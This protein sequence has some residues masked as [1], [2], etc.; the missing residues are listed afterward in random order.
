[1]DCK[2][3]LG[4]GKSALIN[5]ICGDD[6]AMESL[7]SHCEETTEVTKYEKRVGNFTVYISDTL[8]LDNVDPSLKDWSCEVDLKM[9]GRMDEVMLLSNSV[10]PQ[11]PKSINLLFHPFLK[12]RS[13]GDTMGV[14]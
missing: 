4:V 11:I 10:M 8:G 14:I 2:Q 13:T 9:D 5:G 3:N 6:V 7:Y 12:L 1:M